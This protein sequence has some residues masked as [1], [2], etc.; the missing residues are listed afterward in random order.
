MIVRNSENPIPRLYAVVYS[1]FSWV[2]SSRDEGGTLIRPTSPIHDNCRTRLREAVRFI[3][4]DSPYDIYAFDARFK[5]RAVGCQ[6]LQLISST[7]IGQQVSDKLMVL[8][9]LSKAS[10]DY[11]L[12]RSDNG[13]PFV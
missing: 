4:L 6:F 11:Q 5:L 1:T 2:C 10:E 12:K 3:C 13:F 8:L 9:Q 7:Q